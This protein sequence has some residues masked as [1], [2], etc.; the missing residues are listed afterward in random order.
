MDEPDP[1]LGRYHMFKIESSKGKFKT[2]TLRNVA[3]TAP[4]MHDGSIETL[5]ETIELYDEGGR[6]NRWLSSEVRRLRLTDQQKQD[7]LAFMVEGLSSD[8]NED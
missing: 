4:Y 7:L 3:K 1:D 2:P 8:S 6:R 5:M